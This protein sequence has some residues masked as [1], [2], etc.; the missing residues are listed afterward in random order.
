MKK[1]VL[2]T[3]LFLL[4][5]GSGLSDCYLVSEEQNLF[6]KQVI[7]PIALMEISRYVEPVSE[8]PATGIASGECQYQ[9]MI[10]E[11][12]DGLLMLIKGPKLNSYAQAE[13]GKLAGFQQ[14]LFRVILKEF[15]EHKEE[16][17]RRNPVIMEAEC[18]KADSSQVPP[19]TDEIFTDPATGLSWQRTEAGKMNWKQAN[20]YCDRLALGK[21]ED[22]RLP[23][24]TEIKSTNL[25]DYN[26][27]N[28]VQGYYWS[29]TPDTGDEDYAMG[30]DVQ[31]GNTFS[32]WIK[33]RYHVRCVRGERKM[34]VPALV[35]APEHQEDEQAVIIETPPEETGDPTGIRWVVGPAY[36]S[37]YGDVV[38]IYIH[39]LE[40]LGYSKEE[41]A[42][43]YP[44]G[45]T[46]TP[47][48]QMESGFR[49][50]AGVGPLMSLLVEAGNEE[51]SFI[52]LPININAGYTLSNGLF[53]KGGL[54]LLNAS[55]EFVASENLGLMGSAGMEFNGKRAVAFGFEMGFNSASVKLDK[56]DCSNAT[57]PTSLSSCEKDEESVQAVGYTASFIVVF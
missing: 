30:Y 19:R 23:D 9:L 33:N 48:W 44:V 36:I 17:C 2:S 8:M 4:A 40:E 50:G 12:Q 25:I 1:I 16:I 28:L 54:S 55:G 29:S 35:T 52:A 53:L 43:G 13:S 14:A 27:P 20:A 49:F 26:F 31:G 11:T 39:N 24:E 5:A 47:Y 22:W 41:G 7:T 10:T 18:D 51:Y 34:Q 46:F 57:N 38:D 37:G 45:A 32:D 42:T 21:L 15:P 6:E 56:Y 3:V